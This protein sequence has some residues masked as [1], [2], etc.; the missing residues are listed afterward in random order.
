[1]TGPLTPPSE[2][3]GLNKWG[4][5]ETNGW[6]VDTLISPDYKAGYFLGW[7]QNLAFCHKMG[8]PRVLQM[9]LF[10]GSPY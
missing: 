10:M 2:T 7:R 6:Y 1:M 3:R 9:Q 4:L 8:Y 5:K